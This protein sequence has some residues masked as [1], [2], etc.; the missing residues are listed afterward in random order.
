MNK[1]IILHKHSN[2][3]KYGLMDD[4]GQISKSLGEFDFY[5]LYCML[6]N[7]TAKVKIT[8]TQMKVFCL[9]LCKPLEFSLQVDS[10]DGKLAELA[11]E[12]EEK[13]TANSIY[14]VI[15][16]LKDNGFLI[17]S[18]DKL[19]V[20]AN[21]FNRVRKMIKLQLSEKNHATFDYLF[22]IVVTDKEN[23]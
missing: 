6:Y 11:N 3:I 12:F 16:K 13:R 1:D 17:E 18:E 2:I 22:R 9:L 15:K 23:E 10:K 5:Q 20:P 7:I 14:Q 21:P 19:I 4:N 8:D